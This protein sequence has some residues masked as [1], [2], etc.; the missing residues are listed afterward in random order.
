[1]ERI[2]KD[3]RPFIIAPVAA[4]A[5]VMGLPSPVQGQPA[6]GIAGQELPTLAPVLEAVTPAVVNIS[7]VS[8]APA[9]S[10]P[11]YSDPFFRRFFD[12]PPAPQTQ[13]R[14]SAG[15]GVIVDA[16]RGHILTNH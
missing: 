7:V 3:F 6:P 1:M 15:S 8:E 12:L 9:A 4:L 10:N 13:P 5:L 11:L 16:D 2:I 14:L